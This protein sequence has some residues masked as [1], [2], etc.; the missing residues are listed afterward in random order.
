MFRIV[1][2]VLLSLGCGCA[3]SPLAPAFTRNLDLEALEIAVR[4]D[5]PTPV[6]VMN[7]ANQ[8]L[9]TA[10]D[11][12][13]HSFFCERSRV[14]PERALFSALCG[15]FQARTAAEVPLLRRVAWVEAALA[16]LD[17]AA[18]RD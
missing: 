6:V 5:N 15:V 17:A 16:K 14:V 1:L 9:A 13:G 2:F 12:E 3:R 8:Y 4:F 7:L 11:R 18:A 10:R